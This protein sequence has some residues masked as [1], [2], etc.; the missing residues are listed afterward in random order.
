[1][2]YANTIE[3]QTGR[4]KRQLSSKII[5]VYYAFKFAEI[6]IN[7]QNVL[8]VNASDRSKFLHMFLIY[9]TGQWQR[10]RDHTDIHLL[11]FKAQW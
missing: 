4:G 7:C 9:D 6:H 8:A 10:T 2:R 11:P 3:G 5:T 1:V